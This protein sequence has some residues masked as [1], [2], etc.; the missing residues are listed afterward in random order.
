MTF[1]HTQLTS[2]NLTIESLVGSFLQLKYHKCNKHTQQVN[3][4]TI[5]FDGIKS[6]IDND[7]AN[8]ADWDKLVNEAI[9]AATPNIFPIFNPNVSI[10]YA[11][12]VAKKHPLKIA[13]QIKPPI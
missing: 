5:K 4:K 7:N 13:K 8:K 12:H 11:P 10:R 3:P 2:L 1:L 9:V 6:L